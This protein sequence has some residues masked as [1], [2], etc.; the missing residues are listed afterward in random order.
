MEN[1]IQPAPAPTAIQRT[2]AVAEEALQTVQ[3]HL[4]SERNP[5]LRLK[6]AQLLITLTSR[7]TVLSKLAAAEIAEARAAEREAQQRA[8]YASRAKPAPVQ[9]ARWPHC[10]RYQRG[11]KWRKDGICSGC[12]YQRVPL[13][14]ATPEA[15]SETEPTSGGA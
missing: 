6:Y 14:P 4:A 7:I 15:R 10:T 1:V 8:E 13:A 11:H 5:G 2:L 12:R 3:G 9:Y